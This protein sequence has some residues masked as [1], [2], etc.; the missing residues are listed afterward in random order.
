MIPFS[1]PN[2]PSESLPNENKRSTYIHRRTRR[3]IRTLPS[4]NRPDII[5]PVTLPHK[6]I[7]N[8]APN[9]RNPRR[10]S[11]GVVAARVKRS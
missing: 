8:P 2:T 10:S 4:L 1:R 7:Y 5:I 3:H 6:S 9:L 11:A